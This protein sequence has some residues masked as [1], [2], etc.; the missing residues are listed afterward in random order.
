MYDFTIFV[1]RFQPVH[2]GHL[3]V[4][5][6]A[7]DKSARVILCVGS[8]GEWGTYRNPFSYY[9]RKLMINAAVEEILG[10]EYADRLLF[11]PIEDILYNDELWIE[12]VQSKVRDA[13]L[14]NFPGNSKNATIHGLNDIKVALIGFNK[15]NT[16]YYL[17]MF[18]QWDSLQAV[19]NFDI[20]STE[21][22]NMY[23]S[24]DFNFDSLKVPKSIAN[25]LS[26]WSKS[27]TY[28]N[29]VEEYKF[30]NNYKKQWK[31]TPYPP[32][33]VT[34]DAV[35]IQSGHILLVKRGAYPGLGR[36]ALPG[37]FLNPKETLLDS[38]IRE[39]REETKLKV[40]EPA[41]RGSLKTKETFDEPNRSSRGRTITTAFLFHLTPRKEDNYKL[42][43][44]KGSDDAAY[45]AWY[46]L[47]E[48]KSSD[49]FEDHYHIIQ[50]MVMEL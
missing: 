27:N 4:I 3:D 16:S 44:V 9:Q 18:P 25:F 48:L 5:R 11:V 36:L 45:A 7:L 22:R 24:G 39:V 38:A 47:S 14:D 30:V 46:P 34:V 33:F 32:T 35:I 17:K 43:K 13:V 40:P 49:F 23:F 50:K 12:Q 37:G 1:G 29:L 28:K 21:L 19:S 41:L 26:E 2:N 20:S 15:D 6:Q 8:A 31:A 10:V 42:P